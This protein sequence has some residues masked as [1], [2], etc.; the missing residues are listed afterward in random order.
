MNILN[1]DGQVHVYLRMGSRDE[2]KYNITA[3]TGPRMGYHKSRLGLVVGML[4]AQLTVGMDYWV[5][6]EC[7]DPLGT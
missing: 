2:V 1:L 6:E 3:D 7:E 5:D 4:R